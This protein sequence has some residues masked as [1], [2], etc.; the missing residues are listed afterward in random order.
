S[1]RSTLFLHDALPILR[2]PSHCSPFSPLAFSIS[3]E[4]TSGSDLNSQYAIWSGLRIVEEPVPGVQ[5]GR[6]EQPGLCVWVGG[7]DR[8]RFLAAGDF[9]SDQAAGR[10]AVVAK[11]RAGELQLARGI[12]L[13]EVFHVG[14]TVRQAGVAVSVLVPA[15]EGK[16]HF[17]RPVSL[18]VSLFS[19]RAISAATAS[20][21]VLLPERMASTA[22]MIGASTCF[23]RASRA[24]IP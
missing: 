15:D 5:F 8:F 7:E 19:G 23:S 24:A 17:D 2:T 22:E 18:S 20:P 10:L 4:K 16:D 13:V 1:A 14:R 9:Q 11:Q 12:Q 21:I 6:L 3:K